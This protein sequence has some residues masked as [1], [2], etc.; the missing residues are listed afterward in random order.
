MPSTAG[1][2]LDV[3]AKLARGIPLDASS[4]TA[5]SERV[6]AKTRATPM[7]LTDALVADAEAAVRS[8]GFVVTKKLITGKLARQDEILLVE[9]LV[10]RG[11][12]RTARGVRAPLADQ[13]LEAFDEMQ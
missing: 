7:A 1:A 4:G 9:K 12:E 2:A 8:T 5:F 6:M 3:N 10:A 13:V 11:L